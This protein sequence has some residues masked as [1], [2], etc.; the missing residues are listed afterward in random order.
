MISVD[1]DVIFSAL[2]RSD[3]NHERARVV[4]QE[5]NV[6]DILVIS[7]VVYAELMASPNREGIQAF[8]ERA[9]INVVWDLPPNVW[10]RSGKAFGTYAQ[11][12]G[13]VLPRRLLADFV[14]AAHAEYHD[15]AV[16]TLGETIYNAAL[17]DL[18]VVTE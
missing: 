2:N 16:L 7:P 1:T 15:L 11:R 10:E 12:R 18:T 3:V 13:G 8:L 4:L 17:P 5:A 14:I 6:R 9:S